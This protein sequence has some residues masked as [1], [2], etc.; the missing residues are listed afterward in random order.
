MENP[1]S[2]FTGEWY[3]R[4]FYNNPDPTVQPNDLLFG[5]GQMIFENKDVEPGV[6]NG[7]FDFGS[8][9]NMTFKGWI[10]FG[11]PMSLRI[12]AFGIDGTPTDG[13]IYDYYCHYV[14]QWPYGVDQR[15]ALVGSVIRAVPHN[16][17]P[18][19]VVASFY[20]C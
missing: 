6:V 7:R 19:G 15:K 16:G 10:T 12:R 9:Y 2:L 17:E 20:A 18:A 8:G 11:N 14:S 4:S 3:Y 5:S 1:V 13:W